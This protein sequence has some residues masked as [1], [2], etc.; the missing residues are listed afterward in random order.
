[1]E[2]FKIGDQVKTTGSDYYENV[3]P[4]GTI[5]TVRGFRRRYEGTPNYYVQYVVSF[6]NYRSTMTFGYI[7]GFAYSD[8][9]LER[10]EGDSFK[11][12]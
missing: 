3:V 11:V 6:C 10:F 5:G 7:Q 9:N 12:N 4:I 8:T 2:N 1:M